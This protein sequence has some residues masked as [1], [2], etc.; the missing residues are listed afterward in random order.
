[1]VRGV[2]SVERS[3]HALPAPQRDDNPAAESMLHPG[4]DA[5]GHTTHLDHS[6]ES[7]AWGDLDGSLPWE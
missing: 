3:E 5:S 4:V 7:Q 2:R 1:M 6:F